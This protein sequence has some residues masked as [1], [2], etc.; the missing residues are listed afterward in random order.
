MN[1][2]PSVDDD[3]QLDL[4][5]MDVLRGTTEL[6][7]RLLLEMSTGTPSISELAYAVKVRIKEDYK[8]VEKVKS[9][10]VKT[11]DYCV[12]K[13]RDVLGLRI[14]TLYR[15]DA[16]TII[17]ALLDKIRSSNLDPHALFVP[18]SLEEVK[19]YST[20]PRGDAQ[21]LVSRIQEIFS[22]RGLKDKVKIEDTPS[23]YTSIHMVTWCRGKYRSGYRTIPVEIQVR[24]ALE[25]VW[26]EIDH[27]LKYKREETNRKGSLDSFDEGRLLSSLS[28]LNVMKTL[29]DGIA[30]Y[31]D[32]IKIQLDEVDD[33]RLR[34]SNSK[35]AE[36]SLSLL[37]A[38][39]DIPPGLKSSLSAAVDLANEVI[40]L[41]SSGLS[42]SDRR[43]AL[44]RALSAF[45]ALRV[46]LQLTSGLGDDA[47]KTI[48]YIVEAERALILFEIGN[49]LEGG[50][51]ILA[52][53]SKAYVDLQSRFPDKVILK[54]RHAKVLDAMGDRDTAIALLHSA[55]PQID[56]DRSL[57]PGHWLRF[58][59]RRVLGVLLW[60]RGDAFRRSARNSAAADEM[61]RGLLFIFLEA[62]R[63]THEVYTMIQSLE[64]PHDAAAQPERAKTANNLLWF[65]LEYLDEGG[66]PQHLDPGFNPDL[67]DRYLAEMQAGQLGDQED[68]RVLDTARRAYEHLQ[69]P[70]KA[71]AAATKLLE[72]H[73]AEGSER[74]MQVDDDMV[75]AARATLGHS[76][77]DKAG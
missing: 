28:H 10:R 64:P 29:V 63:I 13:L 61:G 52:Q 2:I 58:A 38:V 14:V 33:F 32:Q 62:Y 57:P 71:R 66:S 54:Y 53:A 56:D 20:N 34:S 70:E 18:N 49:G 43:V 39:E 59:A 35:Q 24:T 68:Q 55:I 21:G 40:S 65:A 37:D 41:R 51:T 9:K 23:N 50:T 19:I 11:P 48:S 17:P 42:Q 73:R 12:K 4:D 67:I 46:D 22:A 47:A 76:S 7:N 45:D 74:P 69:A 77:A 5:T 44:R 3:N 6:R 25:D 26:S 75:R 31:A 1:A 8:I 27:S 60:E 15:L 16:L 72:R 36:N 30:Q